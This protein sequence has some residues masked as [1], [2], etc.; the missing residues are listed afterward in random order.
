MYFFDPVMGRRRQARL[1]DKIKSAAYQLENAL[2]GAACDLQN[3]AQGLAAETRAFFRSE[4]VPDEILH[5]RVRSAMGR[6]VSHPGAIEV[7]VSDGRVVLRGKIPAGEMQ[8]LLRCVW[9]VRG[10]TRMAS[11]SEDF[12]DP[13]TQVGKI[14]ALF[15]KSERQDRQTTKP[16]YVQQS[17]G[18]GAPRT[19]RTV[20]Q[21]ARGLGLGF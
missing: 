7:I 14:P 16:R 18:R 17:R 9:S 5:E 6:Y 10:V 21:A 13:Q 1:K 19:G 2:R 8:A 4:D 3:R 15:A 12:H 20:L 11:R